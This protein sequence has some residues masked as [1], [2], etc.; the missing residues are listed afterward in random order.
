MQMNIM[1]GYDVK[2]LGH[3]SA[4]YLHRFMGAQILSLADRNKYVADS[5][6]VPVPI[7]QLLSKDHAGKLRAKI[8]PERAL[9]EVKASDL[10]STPGGS[11]THLTVVDRAG[12]MVALT[13]TLGGLFGSYVVVGDTGLFFSNQMRHMH[14]DPTSPSA[15]RGG[16]R[17]RSNQSPTIV[18][19]KDGQPILA[20]GS[21]GGDGIWQRVP[22]GIMNVI[23]FGMDIQ[24][25]CS[26]PR[27]NYGGHQETGLS[28]KD[29]WLVEDRVPAA[30]IEKL[31]S[32]GHTIKVVP[33]EGGR[34]NG[35]ARDP[36]TGMLTGGADPRGDTYVMGW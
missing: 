29:E 13:Q 11:T 31:R 3:N 18:T 28:L 6:A 9:S 5:A 22:Q 2:A 15:I 34:L 26:Q 24:E 23:D 8:D 21:P 17:P 35:I 32:M 14:L 33:T 1:E 16:I 27:F 12:N 20:L 19:N 25:A 7:E 10:S 36:T 4:P 30:V